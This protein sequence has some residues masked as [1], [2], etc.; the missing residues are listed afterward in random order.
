MSDAIPED[1]IPVLDHGFVRLDGV[2]ADDLS[3]A[4]AARVSFAR[5]KTELDES[6]EGLIRFLMRDRAWL[7]RRW[8]RGAT[9]SGWR[10][11]PEV[12][13]SEQFATRSPLGTLEYQPALRLVRK[14][15]KGHMIGFKGM[16]IDLLVTP[17]HRVLTSGMTTLEGRRNAMFSFSPAHAVLWKAHRHVATASWAGPEPETLTFGRFNLPARSLLRLVGFFVG[18]GHFG[19]RQD[20]NHITFNLRKEREIAYL[21]DLAVETGLEV[22]LSKSG[23]R[24]I[25][26]PQ[27]LRPLFRSCYRDGEKVI[28]REFLELGPHSLGALYEGLLESDGSRHVR[29]GRR[30]RR[31]TRPRAASWPTRC[32]NSH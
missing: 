27:D 4:N 15:F 20:A 2:M 1:A 12:N 18:D 10:R 14:E 7:L 23:N 11:W 32:K 3:V 17:D 25:S 26:V 13:G 28:P 31:R 24:A 21:D 8:D 19:S 9:D 5:R 29:P 30:T 16:S 22:K 6:D